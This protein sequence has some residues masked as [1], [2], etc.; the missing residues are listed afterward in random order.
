[1][2][3]AVCDV[4]ECFLVSCSIDC[5][6]SVAVCVALRD[7]FLNIYVCKCVCASSAC[8]NTLQHAATRCNTLQHAAARCNTLQRT[9]LQLFS[10]LYATTHEPAQRKKQPSNNEFVFCSVLQCVAVCCQLMNLLSERNS[11]QTMSSCFAVFCQWW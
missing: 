3:V 6:S 7:I 8:H 9:N 5:S 11:H 10:F 4:A 1:M 2:C